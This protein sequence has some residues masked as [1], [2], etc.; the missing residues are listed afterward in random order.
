MAST[1]DGALSGKPTTLED[2]R[3]QNE[4][5]Q[6]QLTTYAPLFYTF[7]S[8]CIIFF[9]L[10]LVIFGNDVITRWCCCCFSNEKHRKKSTSGCH[11]DVDIELANLPRVSEALRRETS[12][13][14]NDRCLDRVKTAVLSDN[15]A[16]QQQHLSSHSAAVRRPSAAKRP[17]FCVMTPG[18]TSVFV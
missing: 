12:Q 7:M 3:A 11:Q 16:V 18:G 5:L 17:A 1:L 9:I 14:T 4:D 8:L 2:L 10:A 15:S 6:R 13:N